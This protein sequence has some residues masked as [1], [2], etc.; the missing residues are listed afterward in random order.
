MAWAFDRRDNVDEKQRLGHQADQAWTLTA[1][2]KGIAQQPFRG[3]R[4]PV[5]VRFSAHAEVHGGF[6][7]PRT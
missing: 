6:P 1:P 4:P 7:F 3:G 2:L 5:A